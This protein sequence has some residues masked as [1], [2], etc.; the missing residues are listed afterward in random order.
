MVVVMV[1]VVVAAVAMVFVYDF[2]FGKI[3]HVVLR[4]IEAPGISVT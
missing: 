1:L 4:M 3:G 2:I